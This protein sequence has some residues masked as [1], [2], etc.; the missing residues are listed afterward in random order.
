M[1]MR[2]LLWLQRDNDAARASEAVRVG[3]FYVEV[4]NDPNT[5]GVGDWVVVADTDD[6]PHRSRGVSLARKAGATTVAL[7]MFCRW[8]ELTSKERR[9]RMRRPGSANLRRLDL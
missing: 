6:E 2:V 5:V 8:V 3:R 4:I 7:S 9:A 1:I